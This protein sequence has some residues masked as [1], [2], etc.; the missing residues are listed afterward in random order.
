[1]TADAAVEG[2]RQVDANGTIGL[3]SSEPDPPYNRPPLTKGLWNGTQVES[4]WRH[5]EARRAEIH[6]GKVVVKIDLQERQA[7]DDS[8][9]TYRFEKLLLATGGRPRRL[10]FQSD[11]VIY[12]RSVQD[13]RRLRALTEKGTRFLVIG[14]GFIGSEIAASLTTNKKKVTMVFPGAAICDRIFPADLSNFLNNF[15]TGKGVE[16]LAGDSVTGIQTRK[17]RAVVSL[18]SGREVEVDGVVAGLGI[19]PN[20]ELAQEAGLRVEKGIV[21][22][23]FL[24]TNQSDVFAAGDVAEFYSPALGTRLRVEHEDNANT[25]GRRVG[26]NMAG[27]LA[28]YHHLPYFYSDLFELGY[29]AVGELSAELETTADWRDPF[30]EGVVYF[31]REGR[32]RGVLL[33]NIFG[34]VDAARELIAN[35]KTVRPEELKQDL[36]KAA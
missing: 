6:L 33:W 9:R 32:I 8:G 18:R 22:D 35:H 31:R 36:L 14:G 13:Y 3:I 29:E 1:M 11:Q 4:I 26:R 24:R 16:V 27:D 30:H 28:P 21:V 17:G 20:V 5:T 7:Q 12:Y 23:E 10:P 2:I 19:L 15:Y 34:L 25:M